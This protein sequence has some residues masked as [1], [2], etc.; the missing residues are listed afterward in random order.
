[1][2]AFQDQIEG[3]VVVVVPQVVEVLRNSFYRMY[4]PPRN[5]IVVHLDRQRKI[6]LLHTQLVEHRIQNLRSPDRRTYPYVDCSTLG[7]RRSVVGTFGL[8]SMGVSSRGSCWDYI[9]DDGVVES[10][11]KVWVWEQY[12]LMQRVWN[13]RIDLVWFAYRH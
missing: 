5:P 1:V 6:S 4:Y 2:V 11:L 3:F 9:V 12:L 8:R 13:H 7:I 10:G